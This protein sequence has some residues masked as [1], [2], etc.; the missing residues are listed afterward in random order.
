MKI[1][2]MNAGNI[3]GALL[4]Y[5]VRQLLKNCGFTNVHADNLFSFER[6]GSFLDKWQRC[7]A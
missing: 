4:E 2:K 1:D 3:K 5:I 6:G 7:G